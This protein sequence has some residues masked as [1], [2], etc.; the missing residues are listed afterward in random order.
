MKLL[1]GVFIAF[2]VAAFAYAEMENDD[3]DDIDLA[4]LLLEEEPPAPDAANTFGRCVDRWG[5]RYCQQ[6]R[7][8]CHHSSMRYN[9]ART[10]GYGC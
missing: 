10:C 8:F 1:I 2:S 6:K 9:C 4:S 7:R 3:L 5:Y